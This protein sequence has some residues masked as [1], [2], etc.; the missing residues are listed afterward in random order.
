MNIIALVMAGGKGSRMGIYEEKPLIKINDK[1]MIEHIL[2]VLYG[3]KEFNEIVVAVSKHTPKTKKF[4]GN[5][6]VKT[7][8]TPG[9]GYI[10]DIKFAIEKLKNNSRYFLTI[11]A[12]L[13]LINK[14]IIYKVLECHKKSKKPALTVMVQLKD[15]EK[16]GVKVSYKILKNNKLLTPVGINMID[17]NE[18]GKE[19][20][21]EEI[22]VLNEV[23]QLI[24]VNTL[25]DLK[26]VKKILK[27]ID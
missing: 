25:N 1:T 18:V 22:L 24:N 21:D 7:I 3:I 8:E 23:K 14:K 5:L 15:Y 20:I 16:L 6:K 11:S 10:E 12:D 2:D 9:N 13:P 17:G 19:F 4:L 26:I 27:L